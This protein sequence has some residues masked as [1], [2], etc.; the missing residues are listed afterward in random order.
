MKTLE[1]AVAETHTDA[2]DCDVIHEDV[3]ERVRAEM[4]PEGE[5][6]ALAEL[7]KMFSDP[8]RVHLLL[9]LG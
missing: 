3:V 9:A 2:C 7:Y 4:P 5:L 8:T 1:T 6:V